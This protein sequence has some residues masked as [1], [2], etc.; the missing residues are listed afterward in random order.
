MAETT[1]SQPFGYRRA[2]ERH[3]ELAGSVKE[4]E[5]W[6]Q[7]VEQWL[8]W[9]E[10]NIPDNIHASRAEALE[11]L[12]VT[13][14]G[15]ELLERLN[16]DIYPEGRDVSRVEYDVKKLL[17]AVVALPTI[18]R[19]RGKKLDRK[20]QTINTTFKEIIDDTLNGRGD[21]NGISDWEPPAKTSANTSTTN[22]PVV[23]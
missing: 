11:A 12:Y 13:P 6:I 2:L 4:F 10:T 14:L 5:R 19:L 17:R 22:S 20:K 7:G 21:I 9:I 8:T 23:K 1:P 15:L 18:A 16:L 3:P